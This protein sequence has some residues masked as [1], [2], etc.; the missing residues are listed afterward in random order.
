M[1][2]EVKRKTPFE[3]TFSEFLSSTPII[4]GASTSTRRVRSIFANRS[5]NTHH[6]KI[7]AHSTTTSGAATA[8]K[9]KT[10]SRLN[11]IVRTATNLFSGVSSTT[12][13][14]NMVNYQAPAVYTATASVHNTTD[15][16]KNFGDFL[17]WYV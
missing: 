17:V 6:A 16:F 12:V 4:R 9:P 1:S 2:R 13:A 15:N 5:T 7:A 14:A 3:A 10:A 8:A 11:K